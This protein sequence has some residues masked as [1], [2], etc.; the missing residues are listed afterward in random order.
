[1]TIR[2][3]GNGDFKNEEQ[4]VGFWMGILTY[5]DRYYSSNAKMKKGL[6]RFKYYTDSTKV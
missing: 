6:S 5:K 4:S 2:Q 3:K 1:M